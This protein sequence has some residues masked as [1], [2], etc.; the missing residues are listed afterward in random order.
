[1]KI[2][3]NLSKESK[4]FIKVHNS[5]ISEE[6]LERLV[7]KTTKKLIDNSSQNINVKKLSGKNNYHRIRYKDI[8]I[9]FELSE[10]KNQIQF[11]IVLIDFRKDV[12]K[13]LERI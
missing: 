9:I 6:Q 2:N 8:R 12:Y 7:V 4:K 11:S 1:M 13:K 5:I 10:I 3:L